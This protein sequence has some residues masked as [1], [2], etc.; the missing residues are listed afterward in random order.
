MSGYQATTP[1]QPTRPAHAWRGTLY[2]CLIP[3]IIVLPLLPLVTRQGWGF[4]FA[5]YATP[6]IVIVEVAIL[7]AV[8]SRAKALG[9][10]QV[11][12]LTCWPLL[13]HYI[14]SVILPFC[15]GDATDQGN[16]PAPLQIFSIPEPVV[17]VI[18]TVTGALAI[19]GGLVALILAIIE[20]VQARRR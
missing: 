17:E 16:V 15:I 2:W 13:L 5:L 14:G 1:Q 9:T 12:P 6:V 7:V 3:A 10:Q 20:A 8:R 19:Q 4:L 18:A 11:G